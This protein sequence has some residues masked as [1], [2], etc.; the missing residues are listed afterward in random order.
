M[1]QTNNEY[2]LIIKYLLTLMKN[3]LINIINKIKM[4]R[5]HN[6]LLKLLHNVLACKFNKKLIIILFF[7]LIN[8][9]YWVKAKKRE[10]CIPNIFL[11]F[12]KTLLQNNQINNIE[13]IDS[14]FRRKLTYIQTYKNIQ[15]KFENNDKDYPFLKIIEFYLLKKT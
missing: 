13:I 2:I 12:N 6:L 15:N 10:K 11:F 5:L 14:N 7:C 8:K 3:A 4:S 9:Y 1:E